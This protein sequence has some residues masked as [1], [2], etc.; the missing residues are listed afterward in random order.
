MWGSTFTK[1]YLLDL[2]QLVSGEKEDFIGCVTT[3]KKMVHS[4]FDQVAPLEM[5][6]E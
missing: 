5:T 4:K 2:Q 1:H 3:S 6:I